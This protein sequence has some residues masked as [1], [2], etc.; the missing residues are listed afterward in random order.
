GDLER[1]N[2]T[3]VSKVLGFS[4]EKVIEATKVILEFEPK[5][6]RSFHSSDTQYITP[7]IYVYKVGDEFV[8]VLNEDGMPKLRI[9]PYYKNI[10]SSAQKDQ[11]KV[12][13]EY[14]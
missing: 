10:L 12:T 1:K 8:I 11:N 9:S 5:P 3:A 6:G 7:D 2:Y 4:I 13:K 14:V